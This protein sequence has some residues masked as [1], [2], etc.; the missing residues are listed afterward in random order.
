MR[1]FILFWILWLAIPIAVAQP[2]TPADFDSVQTVDTKDV[3]S[4][5]LTIYPD[6]LGLVRETRTVDIPAGVVD[7]R[8]FGVSDMII[9]QSAVLEEFEG[10][11]LEGNFDSDLVT[12]AKLLER[13]VGETL[14]IRRLNPVTGT[15]DLVGAKLVSAAP[16]V[17]AGISAIF[18][19]ADGVEGYQCSGLVEAIILSGL[20]EG[21]H[22]VPVL[23]TRVVAETAGPKEIKL[24][25]LTRGLSWSADYRMDVEEG[26]DEVALLGWLTLT[27]KT[28]KSF[29]ETE[30]SVVAGS[31]NQVT[32]SNQS[33]HRPSW[34]RVANCV[35]HKNV[36]TQDQQVFTET[37]FASVQAY[38]TA[39]FGG[40]SDEI[41]VT[42]SKRASVR[43][44]KQEDLG[45]YKLYRAPQAVSVEP[46]QTKQI[47]FLS[48]D[49]IALKQND[50][51]RWTMSEMPGD[52]GSGHP[53]NSHLVYELDNSEDG[54]L[55]VPLPKG[56]V[57]AMSQTQDGLNI[58]IGEDTI[59]NKSVGLPIDLEMA[60]SFLVTAQFYDIVDDND[61]K[62]EANID[63][64]NATDKNITAEF[65]FD[66]LKNI[67]IKRGNKRT[68]LS[69]GN[70]IYSFTV[71]AVTTR[72]IS[73]K[74]EVQ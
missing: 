7:I 60:E 8:F 30:L 65:D 10:L 56:T 18:S 17:N 58:F 28:S 23:S 72:T 43:E 12:P 49:N 14:T 73:L 71:P 74:A 51:Y 54:N 20:P 67:K 68:K 16:D 52:V 6:N 42:A 27:N 37:V 1:V 5:T 45:D 36:Q 25:Y 63:V 29:K 26:K 15:S 69:K 38:T 70:K 24:T 22:S 47:A 41:I 34:D 9:P 35:L 21:L 3:S 40:V 64:R 11:R 50:K 48:K 62:V 44:A 59:T 55:A 57:R 33:N 31:L 19:T 53:V 66:L 2:L 46:Y 13:S 61:D 39:D 32:D 4:T